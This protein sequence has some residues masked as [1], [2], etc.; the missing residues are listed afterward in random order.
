VALYCD[1]AEQLLI[2][3]VKNMRE[4]Y[5]RGH[6]GIQCPQTTAFNRRRETIWCFGQFFIFPFEN[7]LR[8]I[9]KTVAM[10][11]EEVAKC[12]HHLNVK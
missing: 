8:E 3:C 2:T 11:R 7:K 12:S 9:K 1:Y 5:G 10:R 4:L 6:D